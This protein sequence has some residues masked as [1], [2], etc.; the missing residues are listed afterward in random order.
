M[1]FF[2]KEK[3]VV[4]DCFTSDASAYNLYKIRKA[5]VYY[6]DD[7]KK[8]PPNFSVTDRATNIDVP[9][10]SLKKCVGISEW[11]K[12][13]AIMPLWLDYVCDPQKHQMGQSALGTT[14]DHYQR[15]VVSHPAIQWQGMF[16]DFLHIKFNNPWRFR[17]N[18]DIKHV[19]VPAFYNLQKHIDNFIVP[20]GIM[21]WDFQP[22]ANINIFIRKKSPKFTLLAGT[23]LIH[24]IPI[25]ERQVEYQCHL[26]SPLE[27]EKLS[28]MPS[29]FPSAG[30]GTRNNKFFKAK[31]ESMRLDKLE[32]ASKCPFGFGGGK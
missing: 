29:S 18:G 20:P 13:G 3:K 2:F 24:M 23:P 1:L 12:H 22:Q 6:P 4:V 5:V 8:L 11:Y 27:I 32:K 21:W 16:E 10:P 31:E 17:E 19:W 25:T 30:V 28:I 26:V 7:I 14:D 9:I 15:H